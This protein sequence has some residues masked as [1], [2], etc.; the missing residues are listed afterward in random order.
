MRYFLEFDETGTYVTGGGSGPEVPEGFVECDGP[1]R[2]FQG[3]YLNTEGL[4]VPRKQTPSLVQIDG[5]WSITFDEIL[6][7][8]VRDDKLGHVLFHRDA[9][10]PS[11][12]PFE[13]EFDAGTYCVE[14]HYPLPALPTSQTIEVAND[15][16]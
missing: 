1:P 16:D 15:Q 4:L 12:S 2:K 10:D 13:F 14:A 11:D 7:V 8:Q 9:A 3:H 6:Y 5:G